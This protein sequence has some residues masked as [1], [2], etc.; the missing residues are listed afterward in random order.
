MTLDEDFACVVYGHSN[1]LEDS[2]FVNIKTNNPSYTLDS[3]RVRADQT[4]K[5]HASPKPAMHMD[6]Y[7][8]PDM[9][10]QTL[11]PETLNLKP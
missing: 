6:I 5:T 3:T 4:D 7:Q 2:P 10:K 8:P 1:V 9:A 11:N